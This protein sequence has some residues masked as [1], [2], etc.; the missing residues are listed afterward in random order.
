MLTHNAIAYVD[1]QAVKCR[2][3]RHSKELVATDAERIVHYAFVCI[4]VCRERERERE[5]ERGNTSGMKAPLRMI[6]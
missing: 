5:R 1:W 3:Y 2:L 4:Y 6:P